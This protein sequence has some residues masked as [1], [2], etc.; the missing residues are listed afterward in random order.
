MNLADPTIASVIGLGVIAA[1]ASGGAYYYAV[2]CA[3]L[4]D[5]CAAAYQ[6]AGN[7]VD[8]NNNLSLD[9][10][11]AGATLLLDVLSDPDGSAAKALITAPAGTPY[12]DI[13]KW[14]WR[15]PGDLYVQP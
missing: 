6:L 15:K 12:E 14:N 3:R 10:Q 13:Q 7:L 2:C 9:E 4:R 5:V 8:E 1:T 11:D